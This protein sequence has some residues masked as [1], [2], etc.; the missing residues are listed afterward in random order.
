M[1][2]AQHSADL[3]IAVLPLPTHNLLDITEIDA[4]TQPQLRFVTAAD[5]GQQVTPILRRRRTLLGEA[6]GQVGADRFRR[7]AQLIG[8]RKLLDLRKLQACSMEFQRE[9]VRPPE[10]LEIFD[11]A[12][13]LARSSN[14]LAPD[15][16]FLVPDTRSFGA[17]LE[18]RYIFG[19]GRL[20]DQ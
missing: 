8:Q 15:S 19:A 4:V 10:D 18:P 9:A 3:A 12:A 16:W 7:A 1:E 11:P 14:L 17:W 2:T 6:F 20:L 5:R 13:L